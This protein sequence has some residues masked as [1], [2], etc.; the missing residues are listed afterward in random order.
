[1]GHHLV[2]VGGAALSDLAAERTQ[3][4]HRT[5]PPPVPAHFIILIPW[6]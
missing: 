6:P 2:A 4:T 1:M 5:Q 3:P